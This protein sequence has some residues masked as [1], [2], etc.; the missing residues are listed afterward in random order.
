[1]KFHFILQ[2]GLHYNQTNLPSSLQAVRMFRRTLLKRK[3]ISKNRRA[4]QI[5]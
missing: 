3:M 2:T 4:E 5:L 1:L